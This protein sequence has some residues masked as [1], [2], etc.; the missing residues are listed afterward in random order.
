MIT[1]VIIVD[2][3]LGNLHSVR[4]AVAAAGGEPV[5]TADAAVVAAAD[6][7]LLP[8]VGAF[9]DCMR[10][11]R[12]SGLIPVLREHIRRDKP[13]L[14]ICLGM[15]VL[16]EESEESPGVPGLGIFPGKVIR[17]PTA[18]KIPHM[19]WNSLALRTPCP[20]LADAGGQYVYFVHSYCCE[21]AD[22]SLVTAVAEYG[23][24]IVASVARGQRHGVP[25]PSGKIQR[26]RPGDAAPARGAVR[27]ELA[28]IAC[29]IAATDRHDGK[30]RKAA[31]KRR[32]KGVF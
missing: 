5:V 9:G 3:G 14:G 16:F 2:Y 31:R 26:R 23:Y 20:L 13:F 28:G 7:V 22:R 10:N 24:P 21:P 1:P 15:Q 12:Q 25:V 30:K 17:I 4:K 32:A 19:G 11:L 27:R 18:L 6:K 29:G 8:G